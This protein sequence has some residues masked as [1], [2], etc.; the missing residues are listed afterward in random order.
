VAY[1]A[2]IEIGV[3]GASRLKELQD[4]L[5]KLSRAVED[6]N[7]KT[8]VANSA[9][10]SVN[11][12]S[13]AVSKATKN[14]NETAIQL[15]KNGNAIGNYREN[16]RALVTILGQSNQAQ[17]LTN[18]LLKQEIDL[19]TEAARVTRLQAD[20]IKEVTQYAG[21]IGP[22]PASSIL[23]GQSTPIEQRTQRLLQ[24]QREELELKEALRKLDEQKIRDQNTQLDLQ[25]ELVSV[26]NRTRDAARF[27]AA[28]PAQQLALPAFTERGLQLLDDSVK[29]NQSQLGIER[30][31]NGERARGVR[32]LEKQSE[33]EKRQLDL[34]ITGTRTNLLPPI[35]AGLRGESSPIRT[36]RTAA[37]A[38]AATGFQI[39][40]PETQLDREIAQREKINSIIDDQIT[41]NSKL[42]EGL[43]RQRAVGLDINGLHKSDARLLQTQGILKQREL[44]TEL[45]IQAALEKAAKRQRGIESGVIGGAFPL[46]FGQGLGASVGGGLGGFFG[47]QAGGQLGFGLS[48]VGTAIGQQ[49]DEAFKRVTDIGN[50]IRT[51]DLSV[52]E[53]SSVKVSQELKLQVELLKEQG[54]LGRARQLI[55]ATVAQQSGVNSTVIKDVANSGNLLKTAFDELLLTSSTFLGIVG[56]PLAAALAAALKIVS[57]IFKIVNT[58]LGFIGGILRE[59][60]KIIDPSGAIAA[61]IEKLAPALAESSIEAA[62]LNRELEKSNQLILSNLQFDLESAQLKKVNA[63]AQDQIAQVRREALAERRKFDQQAIKD[64]EQLKGLTLEQFKARAGEIA[65]RATIQKAIVDTNAAFEIANIK[66]Q[67]RNRLAREELDI[68]KEQQR[69]LQG[70]LADARELNAAVIQANAAERI[71][72]NTILP[73]PTPFAEVDLRRKKENDLTLIQIELDKRLSLIRN[74]GAKEEVKIEQERKANAEAASARLAVNSRFVDETRTKEEKR[75]KT[76]KDINERLDRENALIQAKL[77]GNTQEVE[78]A[79]QLKDFAAQIGDIKSDELKTLEEKIRKTLELKELEESFDIR[80]RTRTAGAGL[81]AGFIGQAGQAF[82]QQ[83]QKPGVTAERATEIALLT[84]EMELAELQAQSLQNVVLGIGDAFATAMTTGVAE[85]V[86]GTKSAEEVFSDFLKNVGNIL[87]QTA[88]QMI[89]TYIAIGI[90][91]AFAGF[92]K[93]PDAGDAMDGTGFLPQ[94]TKYD[95][96]GLVPGQLANGGPA[97][98]GQPYMVGERGPELFVPSSNGGVMRNEDMR[99]LM[100]RSPASNVPAMNF[101]FETTNIGGQE[102]VSREQLE[103][104]APAPA[105]VSANGGK[106]SFPKDNANDTELYVRRLPN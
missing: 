103:A 102:F 44:R 46:L 99:Q 92:G 76:V 98:A 1:R 32:F 19:R 30:A 56:A 91:R 55:E 47:G 2:E 73:D 71:F 23:G 35:D 78:I 21:P 20:G 26:L 8:I 3:K 9:V 4:R 83:L 97:R 54:R 58:G 70:R 66:L 68:V 13:R 7:V 104:H 93:A 11:E 84:Q 64:T 86:A 59:V 41:F 49:F 75:L 60:E 61:N 24:A 90:A 51:L 16:I 85:L 27:S 37:G 101:T 18:N 33:E 105:S 12:Y 42:S 10:Q 89:A 38:R 95:T 80:Q 39:A 74:S 36:Q 62:K 15:D 72:A 43:K 77:S 53:Q 45:K 25:A 52:L 106:P 79:Q 6:A 94:I 14:L 69:I 17:Q 57:Q 88:Q 65:Q 50:A 22:G 87:L 34:G 28:Q 82:E 29:A 67:E 100:G 40:L 31:L 81:R 48:L 96:M 63:S 5:R